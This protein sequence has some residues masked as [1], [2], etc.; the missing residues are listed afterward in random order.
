MGPILRPEMGHPW[1]V[2]HIAVPTV[3]NLGKG[4]V[5][6][7]FCSR[8]DQNR[9]R[10][11]Y[12]ELNL[13][14]PENITYITPEPILGVGELGAF[15]DSGVTPTWVIE[16]DKKKYLFYVGW[17]QS[18]TVRFQLAVGL[19]VSNISNNG[20]ITFRRY[21]RAP[22][23]ERIAK[24]PLLTATLSILEKSHG[25]YSMWYISGDSWF[26]QQGETFPQYNVK[27]AESADAISWLR[28]GHACINYK[29]EE[30]HA[31]AR[32]SVILEDGIYKMWYSYKSHN[33]G[34]YKMGYAESLDGLKWNRHDE[35]VQILNLSA[36]FDDEMQAYGTVVDH[37]NQKYMFYNGN[38]YGR[39]GVGLARLE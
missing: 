4:D 32:P 21:S 29:D 18:I 16:K 31:I 30:E 39:T 12:A 5:R 28:S 8:D 36:G 24:D 13:K 20:R 34:N 7:Y 25:G 6:V 9:S 11:G 37:E 33:Y 23:L 15:D 3:E 14:D 26:E 22:I 35:I 10:I 27:Y 2:S 38:Q 17:S 19:A 1:M